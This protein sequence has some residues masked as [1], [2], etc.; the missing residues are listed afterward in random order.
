M[1]YVRPPVEL[2]EVDFDELHPVAVRIMTAKS[3]DAFFTI[4]VLSEAVDL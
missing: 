1:V 3:T 2:L 4:E